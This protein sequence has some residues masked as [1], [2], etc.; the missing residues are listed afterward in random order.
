MESEYTGLGDRTA[1]PKHRRCVG[2]VGLENIVI[3]VAPVPPTPSTLAASISWTESTREAS[4]I[5]VC[6]RGPQTARC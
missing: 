4:K 1:S 5:H 2:D 3:H 6:Q